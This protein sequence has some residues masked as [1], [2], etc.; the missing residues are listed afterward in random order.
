MIEDDLS[1]FRRR[2]DTELRQAERAITPAVVRAH[3][4]L[5]TAYRER[6]AAT[7]TARGGEHA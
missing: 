5:A 2:V 1:Y 7:E 6:I 4:Q 3:V